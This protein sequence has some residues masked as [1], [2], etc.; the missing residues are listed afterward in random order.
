LDTEIV[1]V[2][3][4]VSNL[5]GGPAVYTFD[6]TPTADG[7]VTVDI[8]ADVAEDVATNLNTASNQI[9]TNY[10]S[11]PPGVT[12]TTGVGALTNAVFSVTATFT[13]AVTGLLDTEIVVVNGTVSNFVDVSGDVYTFDVTPSADGA[14]TVDIPAAVAQDGASNDNT[15]S[16]QIATTADLTAPG[17]TLTSGVGDPTSSAFSITATFDENVTG[18]L[19]TEIV[20]VNGTV[21]GF[22]GGPAVYTFDVTPTADGA[23]TVDI[24]ADVAEDA[25][26]NLNTASNQIATTYDG[27]P[28]DVVLTSTASPGPTGTSPIPVTATFTEPVNGFTDTD[29]VPGNATVDNFA[30]GPTIYTFDLTPLT[31][32]FVTADIAASVCTD[33]AG[34]PNNAATQFIIEYD[35][36]NPTVLMTTALS[37]PTNTNPIPVTVTFSEAVNGFTDTDIV[38]GNA[39]VQNFVGSD[40]DTVYTF[41][42][43]PGANGL[44]TADIAAGVATSVATS[45]P[46]EAA[47]QFSIE[48]DTINPTV[49][50]TSAAPDPTNAV[51]PVTATFD[52][53]MTG[54]DASDIS[55]VNGTVGNFVNVSGDVY[56]FDL[57]P[58]AEGLVTADIAASVATDAAGNPNDVAPQFSRTYDIT[59]PTDPVITDPNGG[60]DFTTNVSSQFLVGTCDTSSNEIRINGSTVGVSYTPGEATWSYSA[61]LVEGP[62]VYTVTAVDAASNE[63]GSDSMTITL[64]T[65]A[66][67]DPV[68]TAPNGG[69]DFTTSQV[70]QTVSGTC[71]ATTNEIRVNGSSVGVDYIPG[72]TTWSYDTT[73]VTGP[74]VYSVTAVDAATNESGADSMTITLD[75]VLASR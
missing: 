75:D 24:P 52:E 9:A 42:L 39:A 69:V 61:T 29:I 59:A 63:S 48:Y 70:S 58:I 30:G 31:D 13:E 11:T 73:L 50:M 12:L 17:V 16:N 35:T 28:P 2:N 51:I 46:N 41:E 66:P 74:N 34:N 57:T 36:T 49:V 67:S 21:S 38:P 60:V 6:V 4:T 56:T 65:T 3:G 8:P 19:D 44:V 53:V 1:V 62:N 25:A 10:D 54:F 68:I 32:G 18:L 43:A 37:D 26:T 55:A 64:D 5:V 27:T 15:A 47:A 14:V 23:V 33:N 72:G 20:V 22:A 71:D 45:N 40:G 7:A